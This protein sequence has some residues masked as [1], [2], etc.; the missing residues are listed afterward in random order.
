VCCRAGEVTAV[1]ISGRFCWVEFLDARAAQAALQYVFALG[2]VTLSESG[3][4]SR[5]RT[6]LTNRVC[7]SC[8]PYQAGRHHNGWAPLA[9][10]AK[11]ECHPQQRTPPQGTC[12]HPHVTTPR[13]S[14]SLGATGDTVHKTRHWFLCCVRKMHHLM[15]NLPHA[16]WAPAG[17]PSS[18][19]DA[20][21]CCPGLGHA[22]A[23]SIRCAA[24]SLRL[25]TCWHVPWSAST[26]SR[27]AATAGWR[28][29]PSRWHVSWAAAAAGRRA[30]WPTHDARPISTTRIW[31]SPGAL[32]L[33]SPAAAA[34]AT[35]A[36][37]A[38]VSAM[39]SET[40]GV[41]VCHRAFDAQDDRR[42]LLTHV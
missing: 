5:P 25:P 23:C 42:S 6:V 21:R 37:A 35:A 27:G 22:P 20:P 29:W 1:R 41:G 39:S 9:H 36:A 4:P 8:A 28:V 24:S 11:Q 38:A 31:S 14:L 16:G 17:V 33:R 34:A 18:G 13:Q 3:T 32:C 15:R 30:I 2:S 7:A 26:A 40:L 10:L 19:A 12:T